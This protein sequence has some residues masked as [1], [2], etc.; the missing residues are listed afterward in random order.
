MKRRSATAEEEEEDDYEK[1]QREI[2]LRAQIDNNINEKKE[3]NLSKK[4][5][6]RIS[7]N[8]CCISK[9]CTPSWISHEL[10]ELA[11]KFLFFQN[12]FSITE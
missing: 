5:Q 11:R 3:N 9:P 1:K 7:V 8:F 6:Q 2:N 10:N 4:K 12:H